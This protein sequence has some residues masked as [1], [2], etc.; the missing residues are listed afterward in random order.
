MYSIRAVKQ[1]CSGM[2]ALVCETKVGITTLQ[3][4]RVTTVW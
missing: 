1:F 3:K 2:D 4:F